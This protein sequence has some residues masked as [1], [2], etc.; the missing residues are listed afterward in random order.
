MATSLMCV[1]EVALMYQIPV[2]IYSRLLPQFVVKCAGM[3]LMA[4][5][6]HEDLE[7]GQTLER[8]RVLYNEV[9]QQFVMW[10]HVDD[11]GYSRCRLGMAVSSRPTGP[12]HYQGSLQANDMRSGDFTVFKV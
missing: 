10:L 9:T 6:S 8:P 2:Y 5:A 1:G 3:V 7:A 12:F 4:D 11:A